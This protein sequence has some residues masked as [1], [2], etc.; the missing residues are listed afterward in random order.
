[1][2][3]RLACLAAGVV[4][5]ASASIPAYAAGPANV[6][7][8]VEGKQQTLVEQV[9]L[10][11]NTAPVNKSGKEGESCSGTSIAGALEQATSGDW[12]GTYSKD[13]GEYFVDTIKGEKHGG[14]PDYWTIWVNNKAL[15]QGICATELQE[16][17]EVLFFLDF[18]DF[19]LQTYTCR[20]EPILPL[21]LQ[22]PAAA[23]RG[24]TV[25]AKVVRYDAAGK[26]EPVAGAQVRFAGFSATT[27]SDGTVP[28]EVGVSGQQRMRAEKPGHA[29][30]AYETICVADGAD[31][32][33]GTVDDRPPFSQLTGIT[34]K[35]VFSRAG[36]PRELTGKVSA[37]ES[38]LQSVKL[39][40][41]RRKG[42]RCS[43][44][45]GSKE[46]FRKIRCGRGH[47]FSIG[48]RAEWSY[49]LPKQLPRGRYVLDVIATDKQ[50]NREPLARGRNRLVFFVK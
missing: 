41:T 17:D 10:T 46:R 43:Y 33:C 49:L 16:G 3:N 23:K 7:V 26:A 24:D 20:N 44:F 4:V 18:C 42:G 45:S 39:R 47:V 5:L 2:R 28:V 15:M 8:R 19:D 1:M 25:T 35:Q 31:G 14:D 38:G 30:S 34:E 21:E 40:L 9:R 48:D 22:I 27:G 32:T 50:G 36:A 11:T 12:S 37:D 29:R 13:F 6:T